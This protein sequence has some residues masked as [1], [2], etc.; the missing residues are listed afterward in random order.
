MASALLRRAQSLNTATAHP[1]A[2]RTVASVVLRVIDAHAA[3]RRHPGMTTAEQDSLRVLLELQSTR[4]DA[5][6]PGLSRR[7][8]GDDSD[9]TASE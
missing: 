9:A 7:R 8:S 3:L 4:L 5:I 2:R 1:S 6:E